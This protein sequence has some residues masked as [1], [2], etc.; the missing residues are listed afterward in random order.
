MSSGQ[1]G[2]KQQGPLYRKVATAHRAKFTAMRKTHAMTR[3]RVLAAVLPASLAFLGV[4]AL[5]GQLGTGTTAPVQVFD[6]AH[7]PLPPT[8]TT[9][10]TNEVPEDQHAV[11]PR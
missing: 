2:S 6:P 5:P 11:N 4:I 7:A 8:Q 10:G 3:R 1:L 9:P